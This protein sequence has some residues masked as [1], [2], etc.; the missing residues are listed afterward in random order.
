MSQVCLPRMVVAGLDAV[1]EPRSTILC[2]AALFVLECADLQMHRKIRLVWRSS[3]SLPKYLY[4]ISRYFGLGS[5]L[6][7]QL[8]VFEAASL[9]IIIASVELS[10]ILRLYAL[11]DTSHI[12]AVIIV[13]MMV[14]DALRQMLPDFT[15][16]P[17]SWRTIGCIIPSAPNFY[18]LCWLPLLSFEILIFGLSAYKCIT[19]GFFRDTPIV[20]RLCRDG[21]AHFLTIWY[22]VTLILSTVISFMP[23]L[24]LANA[25]KNVWISAIF[26]YSG[27]N[28]LL[29]VRS[30]VA[31]RVELDSLPPMSFAERHSVQGF[32]S[33]WNGIEMQDMPTRR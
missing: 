16:V 26:S 32:T 6:C 28:L 20:S 5:Q 13:I 1:V 11:Y 25:A 33:E 18:K 22:P 15:P 12:V 7:Q 10:L 4:F 19:S 29:S 24:I 2:P 9:M 14:T 21:N 31:K 23:E 30:F 17:S 8:A 3:N 27:S